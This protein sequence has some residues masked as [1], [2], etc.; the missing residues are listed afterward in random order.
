MA[1][2]AINSLERVRDGRNVELL[3]RLDIV[4]R[5]IDTFPSNIDRRESVGPDSS[6]GDVVKIEQV[7]R[8]A[9]NESRVG[10]VV[11]TCARV[12]G[13]ANVESGTEVLPICPTSNQRHFKGTDVRRTNMGMKEESDWS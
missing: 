7:G 12:N 6:L 8:N 5:R 10:E 1:A 11:D 2:S 3:H 13:F 9:E 4:E